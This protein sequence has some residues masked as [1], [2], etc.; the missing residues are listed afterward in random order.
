MARNLSATANAHSEVVLGP[1][2]IKTLLFFCL[3]VL[4]TT[5]L[6][7]TIAHAQSP[8]LPNQADSKMI[9]VRP[10]VFVQGSPKAESGRYTN[11]RQ[12]AVSLSQA[13]VM[14]ATEVTQKEWLYLADRNPSYFA[15]CG[16]H[17]PVD[18]VS[19][20]E[21]LEF[22][23]RKSMEEGFEP[24]YVLEN[25]SGEV[26]TPCG[27]LNDPQ[28]SCEGEF[29]CGIVQPI[30]G[31][32]AGYRLPTESEWEY[33]ARA[34]TSESTY[35]VKARLKTTEFAR[36]VENAQTKDLGLSCV[37]ELTVCAPSKVGSYAPSRWGHYD[38]HGNVREWVWDGFG[39]YG[40][41]PQLNPRKDVGLQ[42]VIRG[43][44]F[45]SS[46]SDV[47]AA[48]R[49]RLSPRFKNA[50]VGFRL[51]RSVAL[52]DGAPSIQLPKTPRNPSKPKPTIPPG[53]PV[54]IQQ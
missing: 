26:G 42:R 37:D 15:S 2:C 5:L 4:L 53:S 7:V 10:G 30:M 28:A 41:G 22:A 29:V 24:C 49:G 54:R 17:C 25:C 16:M 11:E 8:A 44:S 6:S 38:M 14:S 35:G 20:Y 19:W 27:T 3:V 13:F 12:V 31:A 18:S 40:T 1:Y 39:E 52:T 9:P 32:C 50:E 47:R 48:L 45:R 51:V 33:V 23:N 43:S 36:F 46:M 21:A 34:G